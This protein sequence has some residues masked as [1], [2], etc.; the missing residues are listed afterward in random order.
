MSGSV[1]LIGLGD[2][3]WRIALAAA[4]APWCRELVLA[5]RHPGSG[6]R[7]AALLAACGQG[8]SGQGKVR[9]VEADAGRPAELEALLRREK[10]DLIVQ[11]AS[12]F[13]PWLLSQRRDPA[14]A[15]LAGAGYAVQLPAQLHLV[16]QVMRAVRSAGLSIPVLNGSY[17]DLTHP[18]LAAAG[19][20]PTVGFGNAGMILFRTRANLLAADRLAGNE[21]VRVLAHHAHITAVLQ[22]QK[23]QPPAPAPRVYL[24]EEGR[25]DDDLAVA[26]TPLPW[27]P[28]ANAL[29]AACGVQLIQALLAEDGPALRT[30][31][32]GPNGLPGG[33]PVRV[34]AGRV[35]LDLPPGLTLDE[36]V[37]F[38]WQSARLDGVER[39]DADGTVHLTAAAQAAVRP[40]APALAEPLRPAEVEPRLRRLL[41]VLGL[42]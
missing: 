9:Y 13:S 11:C 22:S 14:A 12:V 40:V 18:M 3:G 25:R 31:A 17:P 8:A 16:T 19:L 35:D 2:L 41:G 1:L 39:M 23:P 4:G 15:A 26:G 32:P 29:A 36:A 28:S 24:G 34:T 5:G 20:S 30:A 7:Q 37:D 42:A 38:Q 21:P 6:A 10:P 27:D 33:Y